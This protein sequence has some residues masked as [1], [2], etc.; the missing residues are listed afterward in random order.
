MARTI[1][2]GDKRKKTR[3][4]FVSVYKSIQVAKTEELLSWGALAER[5]CSQSWF[6]SDT[7]AHVEWGLVIKLFVHN[8]HGY[9][10]VGHMTNNLKKL[11]R[12]IDALS[13]EGTIL[14]IVAVRERRTGGDGA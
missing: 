11:A 13:Y 2:E 3:V 9:F 10:L 14:K 4:F 8:G 12:G 1:S 5:V 6:S 7:I